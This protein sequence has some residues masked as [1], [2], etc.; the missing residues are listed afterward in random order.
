MNGLEEIVLAIKQKAKAAG[1]TVKDEAR[2]KADSIAN[3]AKAEA[4]EEKAKIL[5]ESDRKSEQIMETAAAAALSGR[6]KD[7]LKY[8]AKVVREVINGIEKDLSALPADEYFCV[9][10]KLVIANHHS[11]EKG[12]I[13]F[14]KQ[15]TARLPEGFLDKLNKAIDQ[16][17]ALTLGDTA[18]VENGFVLVYGDIEENCSFSAIINSKED[19]L[20][21]KIASI[22]FED[23][24][25]A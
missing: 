25:R 20:K 13:C 3:K 21:D 1:E 19:E 9:L 7:I 16:S 8:K 4:E 15:D 12:V 17:A 10:E 22:L 2:I 14:S 23:F 11:G 24:K 18:K 5:R 6:A